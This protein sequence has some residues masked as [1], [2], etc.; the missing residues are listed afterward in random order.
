MTGKRKRRG[1]PLTA[2]RREQLSWETYLKARDLA[3]N[4]R[5]RHSTT[6][7][8]FR[9]VLKRT[10]PRL[11]AELAELADA[12]LLELAEQASSANIAAA[13]E[14]GEIYGNRNERAGRYRK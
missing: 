6:S 2:E 12:Y 5:R 14:E 9:A 1:K 3:P 13:R 11:E 10:D 4:P 8:Y 7:G